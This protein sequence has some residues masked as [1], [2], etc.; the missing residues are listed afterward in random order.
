MSDNETGG[1]AFRNAH[2]HDPAAVCTLTCP[3]HADVQREK[4]AAA[5]STPE[6]MTQRAD[7]SW[8]PAEPLPYIGWKAR[9]EQRC[10][11]RGLTWLANLL[12]AWDERGLGR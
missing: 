11:R 12:A 7:G 8:V 10:R 9:L 3:A 6:P 5:L 1:Y 4:R 2:S